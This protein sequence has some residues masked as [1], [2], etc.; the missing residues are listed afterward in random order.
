MSNEISK[1]WW[2]TVKKIVGKGSSETYPAIEDPVS[3]RLIYGNKEKSNLFNIFFLSHNNIDLSSASLLC[4]CIDNSAHGTF[5]D[6]IDALE[7]DIPELISTIN[8]HKSTSPDGISPK[9][10]KEA[11]SVIVPLFTRLVKL[12]LKNCKIPKQWKKANVFP[13]HKKDK[14]DLL[15]YYYTDIASPSSKQ[16][17]RACNI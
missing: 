7:A 14:K 15:S 8:P 3:K 17:L 16:N 5:M 11:G 6:H 12:S 13:I 1:V 2:G 10:L 9:F 4:D